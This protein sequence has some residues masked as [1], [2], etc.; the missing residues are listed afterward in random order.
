M[1]AFGSQAK[2]IWRSDGKIAPNQY[3]YFLKK[4]TLDS[5]QSGN[6][7]L[8]VD[9]DFVASLN[10][11]E[12]GR[13]QLADYPWSRTWNDCPIKALAG[14]NELLILVYYRGEEFFNYRKGTPGLVAELQFAN[15][16]IPSDAS[17]QWRQNTKFHSGIIDKVTMQLGFVFKYD[18]RKELPPWQ[19]VKV[20]LADYKQLSQRPIAPL[21][22]REIIPAK[23]IKKDLIFRAEELGNFASCVAND[24]IADN[25]NANGERYI[26][27]IGG[28]VVGLLEFSLQ[29]SANTIIDFSHGE[30]LNDGIVRNQIEARKFTDRYICCEGE[31]YFQM[32]F[33]RFG[34][35]Y[36][37]LNVTNMTQSIK[38][39]YVS[40]RPV[41]FELSAD[42]QWDSDCVELN[43]LHQ[44]SIKTLKL[45][46]HEHY[47]DCPWREQGLYAYDSRNQMLYGYYVWGNYQFAANSLRLLGNSDRSDGWLELC[48]PAKIDLTIP[49]FSMVWVS[50]IKD[51]YLH[52]GNN[53][54]YIEFE[55]VI[56]R[57]I[58]LIEKQRDP[59]TK[60][61]QEP[62][63]DGLWNFYEWVDGLE[64]YSKDLPLDHQ[65]ILFNLYFIEMLQSYATMLNW[66]NQADESAK[67]N[68][69]AQSLIKTVD[70]FFWD[71]NRQCYAA[72][73]GKG[74]LYGHY[75]HIQ[76]LACYL[77]LPNTD[78]L[79][80]IKQ[81][82][83]MPSNG[84]TRLTFSPLYY[85]LKVTQRENPQYLANYVIEQFIPM[86]NANSDTLWETPLGPEDFNGAGSCCHGW[87]SLPSYYNINVLAGIEP[88]EPGW[89]KVRIAPNPIN[90]KR[91]SVKLP[92]VQGEI[93][94]QGELSQDNT[95]QYNVSVP[96]T[97][98]LEL[99]D[100]KLF[101]ITYKNESK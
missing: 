89:K 10:G 62:V 13:F 80:H 39:N 61:Y 67:F 5:P 43:R 47:E 44:A 7:R 1:K 51:Y 15:L 37:Q 50:S 84:L 21:K 25:Y 82:V 6:L 88:L 33:R 79:A 74:K 96:D 95:W 12:V 53:D 11:Q 60:L 40:L 8:V 81:K 54:I 98:K 86:L 66:S 97:V 49:I 30:H 78:K 94:L 91:F 85:M 42:G 4:F 57:I 18:S 77:R 87:S 90:C 32:P 63:E 48:A 27:D 58:K 93:T 28:E 72:F 56:K 41:E 35:R 16:I 64:G 26:F 22:L 31:N 9:S 55:E 19:N 101:N 99:N 3:V 2:W 20:A 24:Q 69:Q 46:M 100:R 75:E 38:I 73:Y 83:T 29:A 70:N 34:C 23:L 92:T 76:Y 71:E 14:E 36:L 68:E 17:Y 65:S 52:S 45:C 59:K